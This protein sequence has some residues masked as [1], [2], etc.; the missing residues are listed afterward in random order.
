MK[1]AWGKIVNCY[2]LNCDDC[3]YKKHKDVEC[4]YKK[5][6]GIKKIDEPKRITKQL[7]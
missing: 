7:K 1:E 6:T 5:D 4:N 2:S 3:H